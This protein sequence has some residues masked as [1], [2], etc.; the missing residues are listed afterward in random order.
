MSF[1]EIES[2]Y[3]ERGL[4]LII[5]DSGNRLEL[6]HFFNLIWNIDLENLQGS[7]SR[8]LD[9]VRSN[10]MLKDLF[11]LGVAVEKAWKL[12]ESNRTWF[13]QLHFCEY[14]PVKESRILIEKPYYYPFHWEPFYSSWILISHNV[15]R[16]QGSQ[17]PSKNSHRGSANPPPPQAFI[18]KDY[19]IRDPGD[20]GSPP[21]NYSGHKFIRLEVKGFIVVQQLSGAMEIQLVPHY[22]C[23][24]LC[25]PL[26]FD[27]IEGESLTVTTDL[28]QVSY[29]FIKSVAG[30]VE[31]DEKDKCRPQ[32]N[33]IK[34][35]GIASIMEFEW[36]PSEFAQ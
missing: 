5:A 18:D 12:T 10:L 27:L 11:H 21:S 16:N 9:N 29:R 30:R 7:F 14:E 33:D 22:P 35:I 2:L 26:R 1:D 8:C 4:P 31:Q 3:L 28:W 36:S 24:D 19:F 32:I 34:D 15:F 23:K 20:Q 13:L 17:Y 6:Q 25:S